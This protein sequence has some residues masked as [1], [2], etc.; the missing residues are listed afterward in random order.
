[1]T[2][3]ILSKQSRK[4]KQDYKSMWEAKKKNIENLTD[5]I[6]IYNRY[7]RLNKQTGEPVKAL[8]HLL[9]VQSALQDLTLVVQAEIN[10]V[11]EEIN[12][13]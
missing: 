1:M 10:S 2:R 3:S 7:A 5:F 12:K 9:H 6:D 13:G 8:Y 11:T 4:Q